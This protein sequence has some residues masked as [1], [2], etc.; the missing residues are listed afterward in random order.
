MFPLPRMG[1]TSS[2]QILLPSIKVNHIYYFF[3]YYFP[4]S[5]IKSSLIFPL[6][7][8]E[9]PL[10]ILLFKTK[11]PL[12]LL[13][14]IESF[15]YIYYTI[16]VYYLLWSCS[17]QIIVLFVYEMQNLSI[18]VLLDSFFESMHSSLLVLLSRLHLLISLDFVRE[19]T[20]ELLLH[21]HK[22]WT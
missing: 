7:T 19:T 4:L 12:G 16:I 18:Q 2:P 22:L 9:S 15:V 6:S 21:H 3:P 20:L 17:R 5:R 13:I 8:I 11:L 14:G 10:N 1:I